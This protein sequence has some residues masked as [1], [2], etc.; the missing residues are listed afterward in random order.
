MTEGEIMGRICDLLEQ[1]ATLWVD[2]VDKGTP[3]V[4]TLHNG[5]LS[6]AEGAYF[7]ACQE[8]GRPVYH[9]P[10]WDDE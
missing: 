8:A 5:F 3:P 9:D 4:G 1:A 10:M 7:A 2:H 6:N